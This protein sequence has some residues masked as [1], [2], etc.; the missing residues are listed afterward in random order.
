MATFE[1]Q[2]K[3]NSHSNLVLICLFYALLWE[4]VLGSNLAHSCKA[5]L[6]LYKRKDMISKCLIRKW[7][8]LARQLGQES[9]GQIQMT[10]QQ[11][12][13]ILWTKHNNYLCSSFAYVRTPVKESIITSTAPYGV[14]HF[15][16]RQGHYFTVWVAITVLKTA[17]ESQDSVFPAMTGTVKR[18]NYIS[19][20]AC[21][22][23]RRSKI[24]WS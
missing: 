19:W 2:L 3:E 4:V 10:E 5:F 20:W 17:A 14:I 16:R 15:I 7:W 24:W 6:L 9:T 18:F 22:Q 21:T 23:H 11:I 12:Y 1:R 8:H 13:I